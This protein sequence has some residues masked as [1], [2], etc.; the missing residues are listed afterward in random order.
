MHSRIVIMVV[1]VLSGVGVASVMSVGAAPSPGRTGYI[2][3]TTATL[4]L[5][6]TPEGRKL[7]PLFC[8]GSPYYD[9]TYS[10]PADPRYKPLRVG[11]TQNALDSG[12][13][14]GF[15]CWQVPWP[16]T[17]EGKTPTTPWYGAWRADIH[18]TITGRIVI[19]SSILH[20]RP[21]WAGC[22]PPVCTT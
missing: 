18:T 17:P 13:W 8:L 6:Q 15:S 7:G 21:E 11:G 14:R 2:T 4:K 5:L 16:L 19:D 22:P 1:A 20:P 3:G 12:R 9:N 10:N